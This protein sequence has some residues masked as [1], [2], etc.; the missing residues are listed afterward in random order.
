MSYVLREGMTK[1]VRR[2][3]GCYSGLLAT[4]ITSWRSA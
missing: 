1:V 3:L 4:R 2:D